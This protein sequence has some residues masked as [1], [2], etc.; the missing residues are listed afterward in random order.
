[1]VGPKVKVLNEAAA[2]NDANIDAKAMTIVRLLIFRKTDELILVGDDK[3][4]VNRM[5]KILVGYNK[6]MVKMHV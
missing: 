3:N 4:M 6:N 5:S 1:M 2:A